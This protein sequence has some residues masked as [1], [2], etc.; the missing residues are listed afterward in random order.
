MTKCEHQYWVELTQGEAAPQ[1]TYGFQLAQLVGE[2]PDPAT[3]LPQVIFFMGR[4]LKDQALRHICGHNYRGQSRHHQH[5]NIRSDNRTWRSAQP[6]IFADCNPTHRA[7]LPGFTSPHI[8]HREQIFPIDVSQTEY[9]L[10]DIVLARLLFLF[11]DVLCTFADDIGGLG[12]VRELLSTW[13]RLGSASTLHRA[14]RPRVI[15]VLGGQIQSITHS[16]LEEEDFLFEL[17]HVGELPFFTVFGDIQITRL[18]GE[19]LS[20]EA[21]FMALGSDISHQLHNSKL[22]REHQQA[23]FSAVHTNAFFELALQHISTDPLSSFDFIRASREGNPVDGSFIS[24]LI[25]FLEVGNKSRAP[26]D[27]MASYI[28]SAILMDAYPP[29]MHRFPPSTVFQVLYREGCYIA[30]RHCYST[31][32]LAIMQCQ[33]IQNHLIAHFEAMVAQSALSAEVHKCNLGR[34]K[35]YWTW[36]RSNRTCLWCIR[37]N[38]EHSQACGHTICD[39][40]TEIFGDPSPHTENEYLIHQ[41]V[42]CGG[43]KCLT[44]TLPPPTAAPRVLS[45][46]GGGPRGVIPLENL[47]ILQELI[48]PALPIGNLFDLNV[49]TSS[50]GIIALTMTILKMDIS[51]C[52]VLFRELARKIFSPLRR[53]R[54]LS[55]LLTDGAYDTKVLEETL[56]DHF[57]ATRRMFD[58]PTSFVSSGRVAVTATSIADGTAYIFANYNG[59]APHR[60]EIAYGRLRSDL[61]NEPFV[62]QVARATAAAP[63]LFSTI[64]IPGLGTFQDG[65]MKR[66]NNPV[67]LALSEARHLWPNAAGPDILISLGTG[68]EAP[69]VPARASRFRNIL[70]DGWVPRIYRSVKSSFDGQTIWREL[71]GLLDDDVRGDYFRFDSSF[72]SGLPAMDNTDCMDFLSERVRIQ[73]GDCRSHQD[74]V[75]ALLTAC[76]FF[77]L[78]TMPE[79]RTGLFHCV[80]T[81]RCRAPAEPL[82]ARLALIEGQRPDFFK[83]NINLGLSLSPDN[84]CQVCRR[85]A[86]PVRFF[87]RDLQ[88]RITL[89]LRFGSTTRRLSAFPNNIQWFIDGQNIYRPFGA[90]NHNVPLQVNCPTCTAHTMARGRKRRYIEI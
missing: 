21:R 10:H 46:D 24:H 14:V 38:P 36:L 29:G 84:I 13:V 51:Q 56:K 75:T 89:S 25:N 83:D 66:H 8:C 20:P 40:C 73:P 45:I 71:L 31:D 76:L 17:L 47:E 86:L 55:F 4:R 39:I 85:Y 15:V 90:A 63:P 1:L 52:K 50:G 69:K 37:R 61:G 23:L 43:S 6:R 58:A 77:R 60:A 80:G 3:Q 68:S 79:Y 54:F 70:V 72:P 41:C 2:L 49:G 27:T 62:W 30:L 57:G 65:G 78:D 59:A 48:G 5:I 18:S 19:E 88:E 33:R 74:A 11:V 81:I 32:S 9:S 26:Y 64:D 87:V 16:L 42:L 44:V 22:C 35:R 7:L 67:N 12:A 53:K 28:A 82:I 34:Q